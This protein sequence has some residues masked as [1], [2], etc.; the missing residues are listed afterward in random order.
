MTR[1]KAGWS[2][3]TRFS[4]LIASL[5]VGG[6][7]IGFA[8][9]LWYSQ[10]LIHTLGGWFAERNVLF[11][12]SKV[13]QLLARE[14]AL[15]QKMARSPTLLAWAQNE[16]EPDLQAA[17]AKE[18]EG[19][20]IFF[21]DRSWFMALAGSGHYYYADSRTDAQLAQPRYTL[22]Q[23][24]A[25]DAWFFLTLNQVQD[26][27]LN[28]DTDRHL[29]QTKV[30]INAVMRENGAARAVLGSGLD[31]TEFLNDVM[32]SG[33]EGVINMLLDSSGAIQVHKDRSAIDFASIRKQL[34]GEKR[35][36][37]QNSLPQADAAR[38]TDAMR[39][40]R[41]G[42]DALTLDLR[43]AG[44]RYIAAV[45]YL[46]Q[47]Q[48]FLL[49]LTSPEL[50]LDRRIL[51]VVAI[52]FTLTL[53]ITLLVAGYLFDRSVLRPL[54]QLEDAARRLAAGDYD[55]GF[56]AR[57]TGELGQLQATFEDMA[58]RIRHHTE[59][60]EEQVA[61]RT[62]ELERL[63]YTDPLTGQLNR[64]GFY[65]RVAARY[66]RLERYD[67]RLGF[68]LLD[69][70]HFKQCNDEHGHEVGDLALAHIAHIV[71]DNLRGY[72][73]CA[74]WG[75]EEF[76]V[77]LDDLQDENHLLGVAEKL[78]LQIRRTP[79]LAGHSP[80]QLSVS[81]GV[82]MATAD[83]PIDAV[84]RRVDAALYQAKE[85]GRDRVEKAEPDSDS[86]RKRRAG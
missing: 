61:E 64:R 66:K 34:T 70:D 12:K 72:D 20:R 52:V 58:G 38:L 84:I 40:L 39:Q 26:Y 5:L 13:V 69:I 65:D 11:E 41:E 15:V 42:E 33:Q 76:L 7:T 36:I 27:Q 44:R 31:L 57:R 3:R 60:L 24:I 25:K 17:A 71:H 8:G 59:H 54:S 55:T 2:L 78:R 49:T 18:L 51:L 77:V 14:V 32:R 85:R 6:A 23:S 50:A 81:I 86:P 47:L 56:G 4:L 45:T 46:P 35:S 62:R 74:R 63:A 9:F 21:H 48:W 82:H 1:S 37:L 22:Q 79:L 80:I 53:G 67:G 73:L 28:V 29:R 43:F 75:G 10:D 16:D 68:I 83:E 19:F 30:W